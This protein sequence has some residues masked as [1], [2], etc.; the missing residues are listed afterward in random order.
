MEREVG[1]SDVRW[2]AKIALDSC[3]SLNR[4]VS[5]HGDAMTVEVFDHDLISRNDSLGSHVLSVSTFLRNCGRDMRLPLY[6]DGYS[7]G[8]VRMK[9]ELQYGN[10]VERGILKVV[11]WGRDP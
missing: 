7:Q 9:A 1:K 4:A 5:I 6:V 8:V 3:S 10:D 11:Q 2:C